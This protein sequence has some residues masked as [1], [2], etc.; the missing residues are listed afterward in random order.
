M[1]GGICFLNKILDCIKNC[2]LI[3]F[4]L[5]NISDMKQFILDIK[6]DI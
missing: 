3:I 1:K 6:Y 5:F 2:Y 4:I